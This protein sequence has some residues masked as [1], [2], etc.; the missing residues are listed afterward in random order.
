MP[1]RLTG[2]N[3]GLDTEALVSELVS[4]YRTKTQKYT[5]AQTKLSWK[6]DAWSKLNTKIN[7][8]YKSLDS[9]RFTSAYKTKKASVS[10][11]T[12][13]SVSVSSSAVSGTQTLEVNEVAKAGYLT[14]AKLG[15]NTNGSTKLSDLG[16]T[17]E[18]TISVEANGKTSNIK[19]NGDTTLNELAQSLTSA[20]VKASFDATNHRF[21]ISA[22]A[23]GK[24]NDFS[25][26]AADDNGAEALKKLGIGASSA[27]NTASYEEFAAYALNTDGNAYFIKNDNGDGTYSYT[28]NGTYDSQKTA[29]NIAAIRANMQTMSTK[30]TT[31]TADIAYANAYKGAEDVHQKFTE[32]GGSE[33]EWK[34]Y[35]KLLQCSD[36]DTTYTD[37]SGTSYS[38]KENEDG[39]YT[40]TYTDEN[41]DEQTA[42]VT[43]DGEKY[44]MADGTELTHAAVR[45]AEL[46]VKAGIGTVIIDDDGAKSYH[47]DSDKVNALRKNLSTKN[48][49]ESDTANADTVATVKAAYE[50]TAADGKSVDDL[51]KEWEQTITDNKAY[52][53]SHITIADDTQ[54][55]EFL[56]AK[57]KTAA[58]VLLNPIVSDGAVRVD[59]TDAKITLNGAEFTSSSNQFEINGLSI[60]A[61]AKTDGAITITTDEDVTGMYDKVKEF[62]TN[63][64]SL[65][66]EMTSLYNA[67]SAKG[68]EPLT[69]EEKESMTD[70]EIEKW[71]TK[72]KDSLLRRDDT[73]NSVINLM[74]TSMAKSY[75]VNGKKYSL[76]SFGIQTLGVFD[77]AKNQQNAYHI[78][79]DED[80]ASSS[81]KTD[82]LMAALKSDPDSV[83]EFMK[84]LTD[85]LYKSLDKKMGSNQMSSKY[86]VYND[87]EMASEYSDYTDT[88]T[89]WEE[90]LQ[91]IEDSYYKKFS[92]METALAKLQSQQSQLSG[93]LG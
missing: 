9:L 86:V 31:L 51:T 13:A 78:N 29:D 26:T 11:A 85:G 41:G 37:E 6:Q 25:L 42:T 83:V 8:F 73:L 65:I 61:L 49:Y 67:D 17:D 84:Q 5:K 46:A 12:K 22:Q 40:A 53:D 10:D 4:A 66:N 16:I 3:S 30:N 24:E 14:G 74:T 48:D 54:S 68:Y 52:I 60:S 32:N 92:A 21:F 18:S 77:S 64:N 23:T 88:I 82:K 28:T 91:D 39:T 34:L 81:S 79:G 35:Q 71:E 72:I 76:A 47:I 62:L 36:V 56:A 69:D 63:Y 90:K 70:S 57:A 87:K 43:K 15:N 80:D 33:D 44:T 1:I 58:D 59:G 50:G 38:I 7:T 20:G 19:V 27:A 75:T 2:M 93:L 55:A 45:Q 89:K